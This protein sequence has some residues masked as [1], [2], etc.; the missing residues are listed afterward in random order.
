MPTYLYIH[1]KKHRSYHLFFHSDK[2]KW[3][4]INVR[5]K[6]F[7]TL[8][9]K[10]KFQC[11]GR[12][13]PEHRKE[14]TQFSDT[15]LNCITYYTLVTRHNQKLHLCICYLLHGTKCTTDAR[16]SEMRLK[17]NASPMFTP[18]PFIDDASYPSVSPIYNNI[19]GA[20]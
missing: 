8:R 15:Y 9:R 20:V 7:S 1:L 19:G 17:E 3:Q 4:L 18:L 10:P 6:Y 12:T 2:I 11:D 14:G 5:C 13:M 16:T